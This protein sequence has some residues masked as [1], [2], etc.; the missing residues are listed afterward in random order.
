MLAPREPGLVLDFT[1]NVRAALTRSWDSMVPG[2][3]NHFWHCR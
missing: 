1:T 2:R 3:L